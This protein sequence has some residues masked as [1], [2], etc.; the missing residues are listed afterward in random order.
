MGVKPGY[1][2][3]QIGPIPF[4]WKVID[5]S[6]LCQLQR[7]FDIT[8]SKRMPGKVPVYSSSGLSYFHNKSLVNPPGVVTGRKGI[9]GKVFYIQEPF[10]PH[11]TTLW[12]SNFKNNEP[13]YVYRFLSSFHLERYDAAT[14]V[15]TLNRNNLVGKPIP[16]PPKGEQCLIAKALSDVD[17]LIS[18]LDQLITKK[19]DLKQAVM[20]QLLTGQR[21]LPGF[22]GAWKARSLIELTDNRKELFDDGDWIE[23]EYITE[24]GIRL[25]QTGNIGEGLFI[26]KES[27]KYISPDS[28]KKLRCKELQIG[29]ILICRL[30]EPAGRAC[31][32]PDI[33]EDRI[34]TSV[35]VTIF[36]PLP[37]LSDRHYLTQVFNTHQWFRSISERCGGSTRT[38]IAR[39][40]LGK[41]LI[42]MPSV[43]E[44]IAIATV[45]FDMDA[46]LAALESR[47]DK[48]RDLKQGMMQELLT[49]RMRLI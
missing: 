29:D 42:E 46:E 24:A 37:N 15:P 26:G 36:R 20:Q 11:D 16:I 44:Q 22:S 17:A 48:T 5:I 6:D 32:L 10:W 49:G 30:A 25:I 9:L 43:D 18:G 1:I 40:A 23:A 28:F 33:G 21:R 3:T 35:D 13:E 2:Y 38:R 45:L 8:E 31:I 4:D 27:K 12:V 19:R 47:R 41:M 39:G 7:G 34:I 14:S